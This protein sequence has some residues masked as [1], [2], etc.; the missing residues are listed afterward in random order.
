MWE[1]RERAYAARMQ[2]V[3]ISPYLPVSPRVSPCLPVSPRISPIS[4]YL[5][6]ISPS[7]PVSP[8]SLAYLR[9]HIS[10]RTHSSRDRSCPSSCQGVG[11]RGYGGRGC[12]QRVGPSR[13]RVGAPTT[14]SLTTTMLGP[15]PSP[16]RLP[17]GCARAIVCQGR[18]H[19]SGCVG[20]SQSPVIHRQSCHA[21]RAARLGVLQ[22]CV[23]LEPLRHRH[24]GRP[25]LR[26][27]PA[28]LRH[29]YDGCAISPTISPTISR[30]LPRSPTSLRW[31]CASS[32]PRTRRSAAS[33]YRSP[34]APSLRPRHSLD[35][36]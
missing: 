18:A 17:P 21:R 2:R 35:T 26:R 10:F 13:P 25:P 30:N 29:L 7:L 33:S 9:R 32:S 36:S 31:R 28:G 12:V 14:S 5:P 23:S 3:G 34:T 27:A 11:V 19:S 6:R 22:V 16:P 4:P 24:A 8:L 20:Q 1:R 15:S